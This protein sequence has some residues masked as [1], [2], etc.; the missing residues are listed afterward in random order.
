MK[1]S[2][3]ASV[4]CRS[5]ETSC[6]ISSRELSILCR[7]KSITDP[8]PVAID[9]ERR[10]HRRVRGVRLLAFRLSSNSPILVYG[11][12]S[13][14]TPKCETSLQLSHLKSNCQ[15]RAETS[16]GHSVLHANPHPGH[17]L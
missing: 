16:C 1:Q 8:A 13:V 14:E 2:W 12:P 3:R 17:S 11:P 5:P 15:K 7:T 6:I 4:C 9:L 10:R